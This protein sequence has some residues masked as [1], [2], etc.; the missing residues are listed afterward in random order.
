M[1]KH[2][3][4]AITI[5]FIVYSN[6]VFSVDI[7]QAVYDKEKEIIEISKA[8]ISSNIE[9]LNW[10]ANNLLDDESLA[11]IDSTG[12]NDVA[13]WQRSAENNMKLISLPLKNPILREKIL[14][15]FKSL[16]ITSIERLADK[17]KAHAGNASVGKYNMSSDLIY[18]PTRKAGE[19]HCKNQDHVLEFRMC[20]THLT[21]NWYL[22]FVWYIPPY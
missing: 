18:L 14:D 5:S 21:G 12:D 20:V 4:L 10:L 17:L 22:N 6:Y 3:I 8:H 7:T 16:K 1:I 2:L 19:N 13:I 9:Q 15:A 11:S